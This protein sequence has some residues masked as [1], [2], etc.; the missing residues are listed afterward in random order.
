MSKLSEVK[1]NVGRLYSVG[2]AYDDAKKQFFESAYEK[3]S[4]EKL[5]KIFDEEWDRYEHLYLANLN[6]FKKGI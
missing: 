1:N 2:L 3:F 4:E 5:E 6:F